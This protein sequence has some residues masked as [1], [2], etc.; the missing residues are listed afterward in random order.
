MLNHEKIVQ[1]D[2]S[3]RIDIPIEFFSRGGGKGL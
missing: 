1:T 3:V 2:V